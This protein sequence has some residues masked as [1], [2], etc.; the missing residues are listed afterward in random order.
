MVYLANNYCYKTS[1][2]DDPKNEVKII[3]YLI[4]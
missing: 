4:K 1:I 3:G 2:V